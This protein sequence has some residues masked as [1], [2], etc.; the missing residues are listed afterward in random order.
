PRLA[1]RARA[2]AWGSGGR[3]ELPPPP[4]PPP[5][6]R[7]GLPLARRLPPDAVAGGPHR[8]EAHPPHHQVAADLDGARGRRVGRTGHRWP[9]ERLCQLPSRSLRRRPTCQPGGSGAGL[10]LAGVIPAARRGPRR[11]SHQPPVG[12]V[13]PPAPPP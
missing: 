8:A 6:R 5:Q 13:P 11:S 12:I 9:P 10:G 2:G 4:T 3:T 7:F 1:P